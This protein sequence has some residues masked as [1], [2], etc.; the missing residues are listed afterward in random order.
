MTS[1]L[2]FIQLRDTS[3][4]GV[5]LFEARLVKYRFGKHFHD[6]YTIGLNEGGLGQCLHGG[7]RHNHRPG[8]FTCINPGEVH[9]GEVASD[10]GWSFRNLY[11]TQAVAR[12]YL[13]ELGYSTNCALPCFPSLC[14]EDASSRRLFEQ[15]CTAL[16]ESKDLL[17]QQSLLLHF[18]SRFFCQTYSTSRQLR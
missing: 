15:L 13:G 14:V 5:E 16:D 4:Q 17:K 2:E 18:F 9:T 3:I 12:Y 6:T 10:K 8:M 1:A 7:N 11:I